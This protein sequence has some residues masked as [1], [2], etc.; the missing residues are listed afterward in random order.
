MSD[1]PK[2]KDLFEGFSRMSPLWKIIALLGWFLNFTSLASLSDQV[3]AL[4]SYLSELV[5][6]Y[7]LLTTPILTL[8]GE[9]GV[10]ITRPQFDGFIAMSI[11]LR[12]IFDRESLFVLIVFPVIAIFLVLFFLAI[13][14]A[15]NAEL[16][17]IILT[18]PIFLLIG[19]VW[20][21]PHF[22][23]PMDRLTAAEIFLT[24][25]WPVLLFAIVASVF[26][27]ITR[28]LP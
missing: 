26:E 2:L 6:F 1:D 25:Y 8:I 17:L 18:M 3:F 10:P 14:W 28:Q 7:T 5:H 24:F 13:V 22:D 21:A 27:G 15:G 12:P 23:E 4:K 16:N 9:I 19:L 11:F 20:M